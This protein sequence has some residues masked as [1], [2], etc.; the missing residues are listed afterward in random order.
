MNFNHL[1]QYIIFA[2]TKG[3]K[4]IVL[5]NKPDQ[6]FSASLFETPYSEM[7]NED[8]KMDAIFRDKVKSSF[9]RIKSALPVGVPMH[10]S[11][12]EP[13]VNNVNFFATADRNE[14]R[15]HRVSETTQWL[16]GL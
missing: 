13:K 8:Q 14:F 6:P 2:Q 4:I 1:L 3:M 9:T 7:K 5:V 12:L 16:G 10:L 11:V 15:I